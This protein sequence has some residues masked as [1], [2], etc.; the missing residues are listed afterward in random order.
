MK[1]I[2]I[3]PPCIKLEQALK[4]ASLVSS[5]GEAKLLIQNGEVAVNG[6]ICGQ[7]GKKLFGGEIIT[8]GTE[9][10]EVSVK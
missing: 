3:S 10:F 8:F 7:R 4:L 1:K 9:K 5:G 6:E 2:Y